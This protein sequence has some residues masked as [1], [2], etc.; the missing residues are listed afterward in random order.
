MGS[1]SGRANVVHSTQTATNLNIQGVDV[2]VWKDI[3]TETLTSGRFLSQGDSLSVVIGSSIASSVFNTPFTIN[4][5]LVID[6]IS[7]NVVGIIQGGST[8]YMPI[9]IARTVLSD[10]NNNIASNAFSSISVKIS[11]VSLA[12]DTVNAITQDLMYS[13]GIFQ[14]S[15]ADFTVSSP[16][17][18]QQNI[19]QTLSTMSLFLGAI[20]AI[21]LI[22][23]I[24]RPSTLRPLLAEQWHTAAGTADEHEPKTAAGSRGLPPPF[25]PANAA[26]ASRWG[27]RAYPC[28]ST[29]RLLSSSTRFSTTVGSASVVVSP[30]LPTRP[31]RSCAGC[32]A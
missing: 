19:Q 14:A 25:L 12:N 24:L 13:R 28:R 16:V 21:S 3:T 22:G 26:L 2:S 17:T 30:I 5:K 32:G 1:I 11:D 7:F 6:G 15:K 18:E 9:D 20:A 23:S 27:P 29:D 31:R 4:D 8:I 10:T